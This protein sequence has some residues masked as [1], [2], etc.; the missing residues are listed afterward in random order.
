M[1]PDQ[2]QAL[3]DALVAPMAEALA[4]NLKDAVEHLKSPG[5]V[6][7]A[8][9]LDARDARG[10]PLRAPGDVVWL[11]SGSPRMTVTKVAGNPQILELMWHEPGVGI[12]MAQVPGAAVI[13]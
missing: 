2:D 5:G 11:M 13:S 10:V 3:Q 9:G 8:I 4:N 1:T 7:K 12:R 6:V